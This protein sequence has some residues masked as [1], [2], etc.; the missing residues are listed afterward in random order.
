MLA[1]T[2]THVLQRRY[3]SRSV[4]DNDLVVAYGIRQRMAVPRRTHEDGLL[5]ELEFDGPCNRVPGVGGR[6]LG[7]VALYV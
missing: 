3:G 5:T 6:K 2:V 4:R 1:V 7:V